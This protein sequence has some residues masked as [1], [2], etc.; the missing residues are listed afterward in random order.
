VQDYPFSGSSL[1]SLEQ[2]LDAV[3]LRNRWYSR[4]A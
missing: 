1:Y 4:A 2:L 3:Q